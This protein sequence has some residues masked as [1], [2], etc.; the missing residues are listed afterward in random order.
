MSIRHPQRR[1][2]WVSNAA[3]VIG[4]VIALSACGADDPPDG[5]PESERSA[6]TETVD[7]AAPAE[8]VDTDTVIG[9]LTGS[10]DIVIEIH[11]A[12]RD[13]GGFVT[14]DGTLTN[15]GGKTFNYNRWSSPEN[16]LRSKS[17]IS[18]ATL[19]DP[20]GKKRY[21]ILRDTDGECLCSTGL[22]NIKSGESRSIY[23]QFPAPPAS[24]NEVELHL[25]SMSPATISLTEG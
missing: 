23:A 16:A 9:K 14:V 1:S 6:S 2:K 12:V 10:D 18:G 25:P 3:M 24:V 4:T 19:I 22:T 21:M 15:T 5:S 20:V 13:S 17:S 7:D 11:S 8:E